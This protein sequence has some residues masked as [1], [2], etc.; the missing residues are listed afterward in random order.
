MTAL[1]ALMLLRDSRREA[2]TDARGRLVLL[3]QQDRSLWDAEQIA[4]GLALA[5]E[6]RRSGPSP[7]VIQAAIAAEHSR[8]GRAEDTDW[9]RIVRLYALARA[10]SARRR[11]S[12]ST[13]PSPWR[14]P[15]GR[16]PGLELI[17]AIDGLDDYGP[18]HAARADLLRRLGSPRGGAARTSAR[19]SSPPTRSSAPTCSGASPRCEPTNL[20]PVRT[21]IE[22]REE[23]L[24]ELR[25]AIDR[26]GL[27]LACL[28]QAYELLDEMTGDRLEAEL[29][30]PVQRAYARAKRTQAAFAARVELP[31]AARRA[32]HRP[33][34]PRRA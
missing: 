2:R 27:A 8:A 15:T 26:I 23:I 21:T 4:E 25:I 29:F 30:R 3:D 24:A 22:A 17:E 10:R 34:S 12:S 1:L 33:G 11:W 5:D 16:R 28:G 14:W 32:A 7:Y 31:V 6:A 13:A 19:P 20:P 18:Y 9:A